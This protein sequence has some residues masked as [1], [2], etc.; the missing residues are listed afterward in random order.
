MLSL[1]LGFPITPLMAH[2]RNT[3]NPFQN[4]P[5][6]SVVNNPSPTKRNDSIFHHPRFNP[7]TKS[8]KLKVIS[9]SNNYLAKTEVG[10]DVEKQILAAGLRPEL[11]PKHVAVIMDGN[12]RWAKKRGL[13]ANEG[14]TIG[15][16]KVKE[17]T[18]FCI[19]Y[20]IKVLTWFAFSTGNW[21]RPQV[22]TLFLF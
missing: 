14:Q 20:G 3:H 5:F 4:K 16:E 2:L 9:D 19:K 7:Q 22:S 13:T 15:S 8:G 11:M 6:P 1:G 10:G 18:Y 12:R 17:I 21:V